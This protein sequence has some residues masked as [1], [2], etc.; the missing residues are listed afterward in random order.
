LR[1]SHLYGKEGT[2][3]VDTYQARDMGTKETGRHAAGL[4]YLW[5]FG[6]AALVG[7]KGFVWW[8][9]DNVKREL[10]CTFALEKE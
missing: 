1:P 10:Q 9:M 3:G 7:D 2:D 8:G 6:G 5:A 4:R